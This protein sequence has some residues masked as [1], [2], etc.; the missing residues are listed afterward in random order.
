[1]TTRRAVAALVVLSLALALPASAA[2]AP[3]GLGARALGLLQEWAQIWAE[4]GLLIDPNGLAAGTPV[5]QASD[6]PVPLTAS[7]G[8]LIDPDG[9]QAPAPG[10]CG[11]GCADLGL[12]FDPSGHD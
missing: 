1:M 12:G 4:L 5:S 8:L 6:W 2:P 3:R 10:G 9:L 7:L 11:S